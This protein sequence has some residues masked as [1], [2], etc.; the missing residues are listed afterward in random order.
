MKPYLPLPGWVRSSA[1]AREASPARA[2]CLAGTRAQATVGGHI[3]AGVDFH[4]AR[5]FSVGVNAGYNWMVDFAEPVGLRDNYS[6][7][8]W[9]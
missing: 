3:G 1:R 4:V 2:A 5:A 7:P 6:G 8:S 9:D